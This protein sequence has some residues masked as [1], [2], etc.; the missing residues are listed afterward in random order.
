MPIRLQEA[1]KSDSRTSR[2]GSQNSFAQM[3]TPLEYKEAQDYPASELVVTLAQY[4]QL[5]RE[6]A[7]VTA[8]RDAIKEELAEAKKLILRYENP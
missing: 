7:Q 8:E 2:R 5:E 6:L 3:N 4:R 1:R